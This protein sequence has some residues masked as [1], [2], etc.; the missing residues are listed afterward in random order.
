[1]GRFTAKTLLL[2]T[3]LLLILAGTTSFVMAKEGAVKVYFNGNPIQYEG[4]QPVIRN[5]TT[6]V[7]FRKTFEA[8]G[9]KVVWN[10]AEQKAIGKKEGMEI[11]LTMGSPTAKVNGKAF[12]LS[13]PAQII[14]KSTMI[15]LRFVSENSGYAVTPSK[16]SGT[17][18]IQIGTGA[19]AGKPAGGAAEQPEPYVVKGR[20]V[21]PQGNPIQG[22]LI[23]IDNQLLYNSNS[24]AKTDADG[25]Y[26]IE[27]TKIAATYMAYAEYSTTYEGEKHSVDLIPD[28]DS[29]FAGNEG[30]VRNFTVKLDSS[31]GTGGSGEVLFYMMD[32]IHPLDPV[33]EP[34][35]RDD[36]TLTLEPVGT[37]LDGTS[38]KKIVSKGSPSNNGYG[39]HNVP[40]GKYKVSA[41]YAP[42][43]AEP[44]PLLIRVVNPGYDDPFTDSVVTG[45]MGVTSK[46]HKMELELKLN[47]VKPPAEPEEWDWDAVYDLDGNRIDTD[48]EWT[49]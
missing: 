36:V 41:V 8:L 28:N 25:R 18:V 3:S 39:V 44:Q 35:N 32:L 1:M 13:V 45:F 27:L 19:P 15:P 40:I 31:T 7:P 14:N 12:K 17:T 11:E 30:A 2:L 48:P 34:P 4:Q 43:G 29:P 37:M 42:P 20:V 5:G 9:Y 22:A 26:R 38:G 46:I 21:N 23:T 49:W 33:L 6:L 16:V 10:G 47:V 24:Q